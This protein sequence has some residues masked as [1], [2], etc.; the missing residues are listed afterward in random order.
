[1]PSSRAGRLG[2]R[3]LAE[4]QLVDR[5]RARAVLDAQRRAGV[6]LRVEVDDQDLHSVQRERGGEVDGGGGLADAALL[7][8][9]G[10]HPAL[11]WP[12]HPVPVGVQHAGGSRRLLRDRRPARRGPM[13]H[14]K[15]RPG[16][17]RC[18]RPRPVRRRASGPSTISFV[19]LG[20]AGGRAVVRC[21]AL[22]HDDHR[23]RADRP[24]PIAA[25][26]DPGL[27]P[28]EPAHRDRRPGPPRSR[29]DRPF[30][31]SSVPAGRSRG[32]PTRRGG[33][34]GRRPGRSPRRPPPIA[35]ARPMSSARPRSTVDRQAQILDH[36][37]QPVDATRERLDEYHR[38]IRAGQGQ[39]YPGQPGA[40]PDVH[41][42]C[43]VREQLRDDRTVE[44]VPLPDPGRLA[45]PDQA[46]FDPGT[47][48]MCRITPSERQPVAEDRPRPPW[49]HVNAW[50]ADPGASRQSGP[51]PVQAFRA[52]TR[53]HVKHGIGG[54]ARARRTAARDGVGHESG[55][56]RDDDLA[57]RLLALALAATRP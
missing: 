31:A 12:G 26:Y 43:A 37:T 50:S 22:V 5:R 41:H 23:A 10:E 51:A 14:V 47:D 18:G 38:E 42:P 1:M 57:P 7:V 8:G 25:H 2:E 16:T 36:L 19:P 9:D 46:P 56:A 13:F 33:A 44:D 17:H 55:A 48:E 30:S 53:F 39:R 6:A 49:F 27:F 34:T 21:R 52:S 32:R 20:C 28:P 11:E 15:H 29:A 54:K 45:G 4:Q 3:D 24:V 35:C 40:G